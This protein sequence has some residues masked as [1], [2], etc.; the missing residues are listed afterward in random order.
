[1]GTSEMEKNSEM[2]SGFSRWCR[3]SVVYMY[4]QFKIFENKTIKLLK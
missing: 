4:K 2:R 3:I 1:M